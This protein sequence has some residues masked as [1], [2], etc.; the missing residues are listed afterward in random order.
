MKKSK[1]NEPTDHSAE[2]SSFMH[3]NHN[4]AGLI[5]VDDWIERNLIQF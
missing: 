1:K 2:C 4:S 5:A 3:L